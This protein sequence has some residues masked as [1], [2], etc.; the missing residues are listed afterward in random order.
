MQKQFLWDSGST[1][2]GSG[3]VYIVFHTPKGTSLPASVS[4]D[5]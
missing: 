5:F 1:A 3:L 4:L 2:F